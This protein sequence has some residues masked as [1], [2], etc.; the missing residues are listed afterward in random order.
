MNVSTKIKTLVLGG[1]AAL[2]LSGCNA[3]KVLLHKDLTGDGVKDQIVQ[4]VGAKT[5]LMVGKGDDTYKTC[6]MDDS[7][8]GLTVYICP[9][10]EKYVWSNDKFVRGGEYNL[11]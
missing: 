2:A 7:I 1:I 11:K 10:N 4:A 8:T 5:F 3:P 9:D 6:K